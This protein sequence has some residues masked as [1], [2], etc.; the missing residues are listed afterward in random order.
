MR[1]RWKD[2]DCLTSVPSPQPRK[3]IGVRTES[4]PEPLV[5]GR[6]V[7][8]EGKGGLKGS[9]PPGAGGSFHCVPGG[10]FSSVSLLGFFARGRK[11]C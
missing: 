6:R 1:A 11:R 4:Q 9:L 5:D 8:G 7:A 3:E 2:E 10:G